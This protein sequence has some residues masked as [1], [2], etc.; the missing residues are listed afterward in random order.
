[1]AKQKRRTG[2]VEVRLGEGQ[3]GVR[4]GWPSQV[5]ARSGWPSQVGL[6]RNQLLLIFLHLLMINDT[7]LLNLINF[8]LLLMLLRFFRFIKVF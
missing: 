5:G 6:L 3:V 8:I 1:M 7:Y 4:S 2:W